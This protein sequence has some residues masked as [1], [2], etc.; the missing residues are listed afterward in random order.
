MNIRL[1]LLILAC[2]VLYHEDDAASNVGKRYPSEKHFIV[3]RVT[4]RPITVLTSSQFNDSKP[5]QTNTTW[6]ADNN[7]IVFRSNRTGDNEQI[8]VVNE[9][10]GDIVQL[11]DYQD[12]IGRFCLSR[13]EMKMFYIRG[14]QGNQQIIELDIGKL[15]TDSMGDQVKDASVYERIVTPLPYDYGQ[16]ALDA[17]E[18]C[19]YWGGDRSPATTVTQPQAPANRDRKAYIAYMEKMRVYFEVR[20]KGPSELFKINIKTGKIDK[21]LEVE[22][23]IGHV[24][25]NP[26]VPGEVFF[27]KETGGDTDQRIWSVRADG[28]LFRPVYA[29]RPDE[30]ITHETVTNPDEMMFIISGHILLLRDHPGGI[31]VINLRTDQMKLLGETY[32][33]MPAEGPTIGGFWHCNGSPDGRW[34]VGDTHLG[35]IILLNRTDGQQILLSTGHP[36]R[37]D[38]AHPIFSPDSKRILIQSA[39]LTEGRNLNLMIVNVP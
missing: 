32:E 11:T 14:Q 30:W 17:D 36:M 12:P 16:L 4:G 7:W 20:G 15:I 22:F 9:L 19:L 27:C 37:P 1:Y 33:E 23:K 25:T 13:K 28:T 21:L 39:L 34:A 35:N 31:A 29:E 18:T 10:T 8:F 5:Y 24:Q 2:I 6:T 3:D 38:H 26:W